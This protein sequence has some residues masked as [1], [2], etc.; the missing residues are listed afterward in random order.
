MERA[1]GN[2]EVVVVGKGGW[3]VMVV[4][5]EHLKTFEHLNSH[6]LLLFASAFVLFFL[7]VQWQRWS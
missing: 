5:L 1:A 6:V 4:V 7:V 2:D 3:R